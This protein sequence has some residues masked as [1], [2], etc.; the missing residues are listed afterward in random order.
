LSI[1]PTSVFT[2][3]MREMTS[4]LHRE[5]EGAA[6][7][8]HPRATLLLR[9]VIDPGK[10]GEQRLQ[11]LSLCISS[12][13]PLNEDLDQAAAAGALSVGVAW[14]RLRRERRGATA[15]EGGQGDRRVVEVSPAAAAAAA[16][17]GRVS[18]RQSSLLS[19]VRVW[20]GRLMEERDAI[21]WDWRSGDGG[22]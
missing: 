12:T 17:A 21:V 10:A 1:H 14:C 7:L 19:S 6:A 4:M 13:N 15:K 11:G 3:R 20:S 18:P 16:A 5:E 9:A 22:E 2:T 8:A